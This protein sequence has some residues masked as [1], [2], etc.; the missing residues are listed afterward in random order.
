MNAFKR[1]RSAKRYAAKFNLLKKVQPT[2]EQLKPLQVMEEI[3]NGI[4]SQLEYK[5]G[6]AYGNKYQNSYNIGQIDMSDLAAEN[7]VQFKIGKGF[8]E[9]DEKEPSE[10]RTTIAQVMIQRTAILNAI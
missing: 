6:T 3:G 8:T 10:I 9:S 5:D 2:A 7:A 1:W 4:T